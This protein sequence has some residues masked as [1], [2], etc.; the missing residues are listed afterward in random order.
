[1]ENTIDQFEPSDI[2]ESNRILLEEVLQPLNQDGGS[3]E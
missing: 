3:N 1:M 2:S